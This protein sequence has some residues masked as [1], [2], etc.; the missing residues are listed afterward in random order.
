[1]IVGVAR[2]ESSDEQWRAEM[3][4]AVQQFARDEFREDVW[5]WLAERMCYVPTDFADERG[6]DAVAETLTEL[7]HE[8]GLNGN[9]LYYFAVPPS[10]IG[11]LIA[12]A[13]R[14]GARRRAGCA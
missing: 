4:E 10:A 6:E 5:S 2:S 13:R 3:K 12:G 11:M 9:R 7:D 14:S 1:M 8:H